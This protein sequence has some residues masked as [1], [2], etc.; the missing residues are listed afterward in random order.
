M[1]EDKVRYLHCKTSQPTPVEMVL[2]AAKECETVLA[3]GE[4]ADGTLYWGS[5]DSD[6]TILL[7]L[8]EQFRHRLM[9]GEFD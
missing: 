2:D 9:A 1:G 6:K 8:I 5:S 4:Y 3:L 7:W